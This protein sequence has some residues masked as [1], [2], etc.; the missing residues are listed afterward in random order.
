MYAI[1]FDIGGTK[2]AVSLG[3]LGDGSIRVLKREEFPTETPR[4]TMDKLL[5]FASEWKDEYGVL[6]AG[7][8]CGGPLDSAKGVILSPPNLPL[9][10]GF[11]IVGYVKEKS[12]ISAVLENDANACAVAE[13]KF[14][15]GK[16]YS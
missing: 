5:S 9:W 11:D 14:G 6:S 15:A 13:W 8:S 7:I 16:A 10:H 4:E 12:G 3:E 2:C 1:G